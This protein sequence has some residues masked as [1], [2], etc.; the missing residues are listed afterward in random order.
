M[1]N[2]VLNSP[3]LL[4]ASQTTT[5]TLASPLKVTMIELVVG[6]TTGNAVI[7]DAASSNIIAQIDAPVANSSN[8]QT[9]SVPYIMGT[10]VNGITWSQPTGST[11]LIYYR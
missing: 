5:V 2:Y 11:I 4:T 1:A 7:Y 10:K 3:L 9:F 6:T 8:A